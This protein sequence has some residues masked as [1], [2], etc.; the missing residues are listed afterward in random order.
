MHFSD[1][2]LKMF[3]KYTSDEELFNV[4][5]T[6][7]KYI[8]YTEY[9]YAYP[10]VKEALKALKEKNYNL[11]IVSNKLTA[12]IKYGLEIAELISLLIRLL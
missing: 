3:A 8:S 6:Y 7:H 1:R 2:F 4:I 9:V 11:V 12:T 5:D 10:N